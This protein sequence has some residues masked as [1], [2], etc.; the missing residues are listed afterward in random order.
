VER[1]RVT[2]STASSATGL[3]TR[4]NRRISSRFSVPKKGR[5]KRGRFGKMKKEK[6]REK[7]TKKKI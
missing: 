1:K 7:K 5:E 4:D 3:K 2:G 6:E